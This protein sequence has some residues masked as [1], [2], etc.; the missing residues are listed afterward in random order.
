MSSTNP[1][2]DTLLK[3]SRTD[4]ETLTRMLGE[5]VPKT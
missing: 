1:P 4:A 3:L 5:V 2:L